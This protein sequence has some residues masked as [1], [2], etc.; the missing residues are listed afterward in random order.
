MQIADSKVTEYTFKVNAAEFDAIHNALYWVVSHGMDITEDD[1]LKVARDM[2][3]LVDI[4]RAIE[5]YQKEAAY[6]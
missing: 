6:G 4:V 1:F 3:T 5:N 2:I